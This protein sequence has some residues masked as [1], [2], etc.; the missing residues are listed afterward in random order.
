MKAHFFNVSARNVTSTASMTTTTS[1]NILAICILIWGGIIII[2]FAIFKTCID[3]FPLPFIKTSRHAHTTSTRT[4]RCII[5]LDTRIG[6]PTGYCYLP[7]IILSM[8]HKMRQR[9]GPFPT[10]RQLLAVPKTY[11]TKRR[12]TLDFVSDGV[13][14]FSESACG[15]YIWEIL[16][17]A[18]TQN[19]LITSRIYTTLDSSFPVGFRYLQ[20][21]SP[22]YREHIGRIY[23]PNPSIILFNTTPANFRI[24]TRGIIAERKPNSLRF[25]YQRGG[26]DAWHQVYVWAEQKPDTRIGM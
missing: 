15:D 7:M 23:G 19:D 6:C 5:T 8:Q 2:I 25:V 26:I 13:F 14:H 24:N 10:I 3:Y 17:Y 22:N 4:V 11:R 1:F 16:D 12:G 21:I 18:F 20:L 9:L